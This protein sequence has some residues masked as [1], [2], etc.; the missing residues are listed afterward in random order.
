MGFLEVMVLV[1]IVACAVAVYIVN[2]K[3]GFL[4]KLQAE[5]KWREVQADINAIS[6]MHEKYYE[7]GQKMKWLDKKL[8]K[9]T[10]KDFETHINRYNKYIYFCN[11]KRVPAKIDH[12]AFTTIIEETEDAILNPGDALN[13]VL[14]RTQKAYDSE[15]KNLNITGEKLLEERKKSIYLISDVENLVNSIAK[16]PKLFDTELSEIKVEKSKFQSSL[17]FAKK[18]KVN[19]EKDAAGIGAGVAAGGAVA[20]I[21]PTAAMWVATTFGTASTGTAISALGGAAATNAALAWLGGGALTAG[22][23]GM[24]AGQ[25][26]LALAGPIGWGIAGTS[27]LASVYLMVRK[28]FKIQESKRDEIKRMKAFTEI[29]KEVEIKIEKISVQTSSIYS[30]L[31]KQ[32]KDC[33]IYQSADYSTFSSEDKANLA[34]LVNNTKSLAS[35]LGKTVEDDN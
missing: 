19:L 24:V 18:Q 12:N 27:V 13:K 28:R 2:Q 6:E 22:G 21:A 31:L 11:S 16:R 1:V 15:Y 20:G 7:T 26:L 35:L 17:D 5:I 32:H 33:S 10:K 4:W 29:L 34:A 3:T 9:S 23:G 30:K 8:T 25:A 14:E